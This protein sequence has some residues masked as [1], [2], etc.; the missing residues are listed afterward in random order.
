ML[1]RPD[2]PG[3]CPA[4]EHSHAQVA[5]TAWPGPLQRGGET[6]DAPPLSAGDD[7][8]SPAAF[9]HRCRLVTSGLRKTSRMGP[10]TCPSATEPRMSS[11]WRHPW[12]GCVT[13]SIGGQL[14]SSHQRGAMALHTAIGQC[15]AAAVPT[16]PL[17]HTVL[18]HTLLIHTLLAQ[19]REDPETTWTV[20]A[21]ERT[22]PA[23]ER[24]RRA[25]PNAADQP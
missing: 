18:I 11:T 15:L 2:L 1:G 23:S 12:R 8:F 13:A 24:R 14:G 6:H 7:Y 21:A 25:G 20:V 4:V 16:S 10:R 5:L 22:R 3:C 17:I 9:H 19:A